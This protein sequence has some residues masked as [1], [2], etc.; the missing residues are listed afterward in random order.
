MIIMTRTDSM[1]SISGGRKFLAPTPSDIPLR[2]E[3]HTRHDSKPRKNRSSG[4]PVIFIC[5][6]IVVLYKYIA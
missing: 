4:N 5:C 2:G 3:K 1:S 6:Y